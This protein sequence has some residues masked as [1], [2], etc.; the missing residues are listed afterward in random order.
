MPRLDEITELSQRSRSNGA[1]AHAPRTHAPE[2]AEA[3]LTRCNDMIAWYERHHHAARI[4][5]RLFSTSAI[6]LAALTPILILW[7]PNGAVAPIWQAAPAALASFFAALLTTYRWREDWIRF[8]VAAET[9][10]SERASTPPAP[11][12]TTRCTW[13]TPKRST[14]SCSASRAWPSARSPNGATSS[15]RKPAPPPAKAASSTPHRPS[16]AS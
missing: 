13:P 15:P 14:P 6:M 12:R 3:A 5:Y 16:S 4:W 7:S 2:Q 8:A 11:P 10:R 9:L 1:T